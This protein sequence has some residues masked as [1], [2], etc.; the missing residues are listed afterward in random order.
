MP[1]SEKITV[2]FHLDADGKVVDITSPNGKHSKE[3]PHPPH[4]WASA[5]I[6]TKH[7]PGC[8]YIWNGFQWVKVC[9]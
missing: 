5:V 6:A 8:M 9:F 3:D 2:E 4:S 7:S 1:A